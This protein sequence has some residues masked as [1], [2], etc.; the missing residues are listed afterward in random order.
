MSVQDVGPDEARRGERGRA[1][2][3]HVPMQI[4]GVVGTA[5]AI[6][7][8]AIEVARMID[9][10]ERHA[11]AGLGPQEIEALGGV[12]H[13]DRE[14]LG[15]RRCFERVENATV[16][17]QD[18]R[19]LGA[20]LLER[21]GQRADYVGESA[22]LGPRSDL[23]GNDCDFH[24]FTDDLFSILPANYMGESSEGSAKKKQRLQRTTTNDYNNDC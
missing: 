13:R 23:G 24:F 9:E 20:A 3:H 19:R 21:R 16:A 15:R 11:V 14:I 8:R 17:R 6:Y 2:E 4:V 1:A 7:S 12:A 18:D 5:L 10:V 22:G